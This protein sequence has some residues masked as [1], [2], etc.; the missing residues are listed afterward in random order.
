MDR[1]TLK[2]DDL[3][4]DDW[5]DEEQDE[6]QAPAAEPPD[7]DEHAVAII[8]MDGRVG[9]AESLEEFWGLLTGE[10][11]G[12]RDLPA[13][14]RIDLDAFL[15]A[16]GIKLPIQ[17]D[18]YLRSTYLQDIAG[19]DANFFGLSQ[20]EANFMDPNQRILLETAWKA[21]ED[22]GY[23]GAEIRGSDTGTFVGYS[24]DFGEDY[25]QLLNVLAPNAPEI[26][27]A[28][29]VKSIIA[30]R[31]AY[32][33]DLR[34][35]ALLVDTACSSGLMAMYLAC[36]AIRNGDCSM[37]VVGAVKT[38]V[39]PLLN[40]GK[41]GFGIRDIQDI[42]SE[43]GHTRTFD[44]KSDGTITAEGSFAFV[45][46]SLSA[47]KRD[48]DTIRAVILGGAANQDGASNGITAP[49]SEAQKDLIARALD[50]AGIS[51]EQLSYIEAH[52]TATR[53][54]D[55]IEIS[56]IRQ[57][58]R[59]FTD[60]K[61]FCAVGSLKSNIGHMD[62]AAGLGGMAKLVLAMK[63]RVLPASLN[64]QVPNRNIQF[65]DS[66]VYV[67]DRTTAWSHDP[68]EVLR[69]G[70]NSFGLS[71][72]NC[73]LV[74]ESAPVEPNRVSGALSAPLLL[75]LS[76]KTHEALRSLAADYQKRL[77]DP[78][79]NLADA[80]FTAARGRL[81]H[82]IRAAIRFE[83]REQLC[84]ALGLVAALGTGAAEEAAIW[85]G[86][87]RIIESEAKRR[88]P[89]DL[90]E[91]E[92]EQLGTEAFELV[93]QAGGQMTVDILDRW[94]ELYTAGADLPWDRL[95]K[96][97]NARRIP[98]PTYPFQHRRCWV[99]A[100][101]VAQEDEG[102]AHPLLGAPRAKTL[103]H[104]VYC[105][106]FSCESF[107]ELAEHRVQGVGLLPGTALV[108]MMVEWANQFHGA[109]GLRFRDITFLQPF[110]VRDGMTKELHLLA[111]DEDGQTRLR[112]ASLSADGQWAVHAEGV[113]QEAGN[114]PSGPDQIDL[115]ALNVELHHP[116]DTN[117]AENMDRGLIVGERWSG[118]CVGGWRDEQ[119]A[120]YLVELHLP[121]EYRT[122]GDVYHLHPAL[123]DLSVN[124]VNHLMDEKELYLP[125]SY[126]ELLI[127]RQLPT[128]LFAH[129]K[130]T[131]GT[132][133]S[134]IHSFD[135]AL[136]DAQ[137]SLVVEV[138]NYCIKS[139]SQALQRADIAGQYG[140][141]QSFRPYELPTQR[142]LPPGA[143]AIAGKKSSTS[144]ALADALRNQGRKVIELNA[145]VAN[146]SDALNAVASEDLALAIFMW[147]PTASIGQD[148][149]AWQ[150][151]TNEAI[152]QGFR[153]VKAWS[154]AKQRTKAGLVVLTYRGW[155]VAEHDQH[156][157][158][159][160][161]ALGG[162]WRVGSLEFQSDGMRCI[163]HDGSNSIECLL[164]E[165]ADRARPAFVAYRNDLAYE[166][167]LIESPLPAKAPDD[168]VPGDGVYVISGGTGGLGTEVA[169]LLT[170]HG[171]RRVV[172][173]GQ[174]QVPPREM[175]EQL[176]ASSDDRQT[177]LRYESW[178]KL[179]QRL[180]VLDVRAVQIEDGAQVAATLRELRAAHGPIR[181][182]F[183]LAGRAGDGFLLQKQEETFF[184]VYAPKADGAVNLHLATLQDQ[185]DFF[186][187]FSSISSLELYPGQGD[188]TAANLFLDALAT[189]RQGI[190]LPG[191]SLQWPAWRETG[192]AAR[193]GAVDQSQTFA[194]L[195]SHEALGLLERALW[196]GEPLPAVLMPGQKLRKQ[197][198]VNERARQP[199][200]RKGSVANQSKKVT[201]LGVAEPDEI[202]LAVADLWAR[203]LAM[204]ELDAD[205]GFDSLGGNSLLASQL[206]REYE[207]LYPGVMHIADLFNH[208]TIREQAAYVRAQ[209]VP[210][211]AVEEV[212]VAETSGDVSADDLDELLELVLRG[213]LTVE[214]SADRLSLERG[215]GK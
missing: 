92:R 24:Y 214:E 200:S 12:V 202:D 130:K 194:P 88:R 205:E 54:G 116:I 15:Q 18:L 128:H 166:P 172:L 184:N 107:W 86:A 169:E 33:L 8:G 70:I 182:I 153:F 170:R 144:D 72:T 118:S 141:A 135:I 56:G 195:D 160:Q 97:L 40:D 183:H 83:T 159:G 13:E 117:A 25:R 84:H 11:E 74:V 64:F 203:T 164:G 121:K 34:G 120:Q 41:S 189:Y 186:I 14:R 196:N 67:N 52:G 176:A 124:S 29:N 100:D 197:D 71:G 10:R 191:L 127:H 163:D 93:S 9:P 46:K 36:R 49:N 181:G 48:G 89:S 42:H 168:A 201:L 50:D 65:V 150:V 110:T 26:S 37:A 102:H 66:P 82:H 47:A 76:A 142:E 147:E 35:P 85:Y 188:Y 95:T 137:G 192:I 215:R 143:V 68:S 193:M 103:G 133:G 19:F 112:F 199:E 62:N 206:F 3:I 207:L 151:E 162:L 174:Q 51:A 165:M 204:N 1:P 209:T 38:Q 132:Q 187:V 87:H 185:L 4:L 148:A 146:W 105:Q 106:T 98:L 115:Q 155:S 156:I 21:L 32:H 138:K 20:Q 90:T 171:A 55:P 60:K 213:E 173:F 161:T 101:Q 178:L 23:A 104:T 79:V 190:G 198:T 39:L 81:H 6:E 210:V 167:V 5:E 208:T 16:K 45:L 175:W 179:E 44:D 91:N 109:E 136:Y 140:Y 145:G 94:G 123:M 73:H 157:H 149:E 17:E 57:A 43:D 78:N 7:T 114:S 131:G 96:G 53:L 28:G 77:R 63:N 154:L 158:P 58:L 129:M 134:K 111:E 2:L 125:L 108:E 61:Q 31:L 59:Q 152:L 122:E 30:S 211:E 126:G 212:A 75:P 119:A 69:A 22:S 177:S 113:F 27:V 99:E 180:D 139:A 80:V